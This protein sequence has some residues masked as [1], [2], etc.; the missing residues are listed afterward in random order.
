MKLLKKRKVGLTFV[1]IQ[2]LLMLV[3]YAAL[4][5]FN[6][7]GDVYMLCIGGAF[8]VIDIY[9][10]ITQ[11]TTKTHKIGAGIAIFMSI[12]LVI[13]CFYLYKTYFTL[14]AVTGK[15]YK[16]ETMSILVLADN[17]AK[18]I[19]DVIDDEFGIQTTV[20]NDNTKKMIDTIN[21]ECKADIK[22]KEYSDVSLMVDA[23]YDGE[24][25]VVILNDAFKGL[26]TDSREDFEEETRVLYD[27]KQKTKVEIKTEDKKTNKS[28][29]EESFNVYISGIDAYGTISKTSRSDVNIIATVN[30]VKKQILLTNTPRDYFV[31]TTV[32]GGMEDKLTHAG[33]YGVDCSVGTLEMLYDTEIDY[34]TRVNFTGFVDIVDALGGVTVHSDYTFTSDWGPS[35]RKGN[36]KVNGEQALAFARERHHFAAGDNQRGKN[37]QY[38]IKAIIEKATSPAILK[39][40]SDLM[41]SVSKSF[42]TSLKSSDITKLIKM[43]LADGDSWDVVMINVTGSGGKSTTYSNQSKKGYVMIPNTSTVDAAKKMISKVMNN[44]KVTSEEFKTLV[45]ANKE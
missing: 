26:I 27:F 4:L 43:Q 35:F 23:L 36:N 13:G 22:T 9:T 32:S 20:D 1:V 17:P 45:D 11:F 10:I 24:V 25:K 6:V 15:E 18:N 19:D 40:Y 34:S 39:S 38:L 42:E 8:V 29:T 5:L 30:P 14:E 28:I 3:F 31:P 21:S 2:T 7:L 37:Q 44:E 41:D 12:L 33:I 16:E